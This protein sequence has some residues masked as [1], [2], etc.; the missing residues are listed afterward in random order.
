MSFQE[1][2]QLYNVLF[3]RVM[4]ALKMVQMNK[5]FYDPACAVRVPQHK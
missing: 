2:L 3:R 4:T 5:N 1:S